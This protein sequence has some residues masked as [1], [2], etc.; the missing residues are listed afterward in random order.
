MGNK[1]IRESYLDLYVSWFDSRK[2]NLSGAI[3]E[4]WSWFIFKPKIRYI[5]SIYLSC[6]WQ[7]KAIFLMFWYV[8]AILLT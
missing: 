1:K 2:N 7:L 6:K 4:I 8:E 3:P 5:M